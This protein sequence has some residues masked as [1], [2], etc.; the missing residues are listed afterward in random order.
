MLK[1]KLL[2]KFAELS[3]K[4]GVNIQKGQGLLIVCP[5][6]K[7]EVAVAISKKAYEFGA[8]IVDIRWECDETEKINYQFADTKALCDIPKWIIDSREYLVKNNFCYIAIA[9][10]NPSAFKDI[11]SEKIS[12][13]QQVK[14]KLL[15]S[16]SDSVMN[17][18]IRWCVVSV[19][20]YKWAKQVFPKSKDPEKE[21]SSAIEKTMRLDKSNPLSAWNKHIQALQ[22]RAEFLNKHNFEYLHFTN[23]LGT[24]LTVGLA[25]NHTWLSAEEMAKDKVKFVAN[26]PTEEVFTA[27][28]KDKVNGTVYSAMPL[29]Y[30]G[31]IIDKFSITFSKG[32][33]VS[34]KAKKG[35]ALLKKLIETDNGT[36]S[37]GEVALIGKDSPIAQSNILFYN[38]LFDENAS[39][40]LALGKA[41][42]T[43]IKGGDKLS[44][45]ELKKLGA[46]DSIEHVDF[47]IGTKDLSVIGIDYEKKKITIIKN[48]KFVI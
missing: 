21:L 20:T 12:K 46:N 18:E 35:E 22:K 47:M 8:K 37:I 28:H 24:N 3:L 11:P 34:C 2:E 1:G 9:S 32:K 10:E 17:N 7:S 13:V 27:P 31:Q 39:C 14:G 25:K 36:K 43:T 38:T 23:S 40:H 30:N 48:G 19:P 45:T 5:V 26:M 6:E 42:P 4:I 16:F 29:C 44:I 15:K 33:V 41:Y